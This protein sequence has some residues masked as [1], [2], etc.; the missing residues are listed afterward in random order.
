MLLLLFLRRFMINLE[1]VA[2]FLEG[3]Q[4]PT[5]MYTLA[6]QCTDYD[7]SLRPDAEQTLDWI[8]DVY[9]T[10]HADSAVPS[11]HTTR[12]Q[13]I[14][15]A[16]S[17]LTSIHDTRDSETMQLGIAGG[18]NLSNHGKGG[19][20]SPQPVAVPTK[21]SFTSPSGVFKS[22][23]HS[24]TNAS[25]EGST[26]TGIP[27][28]HAGAPGTQLSA[29]EILLLEKYLL[30]EPENTLFASAPTS[31]SVY[32]ETSSVVLKEGVLYKINETGFRN[33]KQIHCILTES[34]LTWRS[35]SDPS[36]NNVFLLKDTTVRR[37][38]DKRFVL[39]HKVTTAVSKTPGKSRTN[40]NA[41]GGD[42]RVRAPTPDTLI[43][44]QT[45]PQPSARRPSGTAALASLAAAVTADAAGNTPAGV[46]STTSSVASSYSNSSN[47][48]L[49]PAQTPTQATVE[50]TTFVVK[51]L[52]A[53]SVED[54]DD[55]ID[56]IQSAINEQKLGHVV[57]SEGVQY[58][59]SQP[60][61]ESTLDS[62]RETNEDFESV[63]DWLKS[64]GLS[65]PYCAQYLSV[66]EERG[67]D[68]MALILNVGLKD[69]DFDYLG[70]DNPAHRRALAN[71]IHATYSPTLK[72]NINAYT[73]FESAV[74]FKV[75]SRWHYQR[76]VIQVQLGHFKRLDRAVRH[77]LHVA[78]DKHAILQHL[79]ALPSDLHRVRADGADQQR[80]MKLELYLMYLAEALEDTPHFAVLLKFLELLP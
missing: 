2:P 23:F 21:M 7:P 79:P 76:T 11:P 34:R 32:D 44:F 69:S 27:E 49:P 66:L 71:S 40:S 53:K 77:A 48:P 55:W 18:N 63:A 64:T 42:T 35:N 45:Q 16:L 13:S 59:S 33:W 6:T 41:E 74:L 75:T 19:I 47:V 80:R 43:P 20:F 38:R 10:D 36:K 25:A 46:A 22:L 28:G 73:K 56:A 50:K 51:E 1:E 68:S 5:S 17:A 15:Y 57:D 39:S 60:T 12:T 78:H 4:Y 30:R 24:K 3:Q 67:Y 54:M 9:E 52:A 29:P 65:A 61:K 58:H 72:L 31:P 26:L 70:I 8:K 14:R 37:T 62:P